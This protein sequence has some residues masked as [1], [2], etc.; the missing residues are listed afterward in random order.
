MLHSGL[1]DIL[2]HVRDVLNVQ[3]DIHMESHPNDLTPENLRII[4]SLGVRHLSIG[5]EALQDRHL[6]TLHRPYTVA[7]VKEAV[8]R[9]VGAG[10]DCVNVDAIF[11]LPDQTLSEV[12]EL[13]RSFVEL[14]VDQVA[15]YP[16]YE[17][18]YTRWE[19]IAR[20][21]GYKAFGAMAKR[22]MLAVLESI[23]YGAGFRR[24]SVWAFTRHGVPKYCSVTVPLYLGLGAAGGTYLKDVFYFNSFDVPAYVAALDRGRL[25]IALS[26]ELSEPMQMAGWLYWR[27]Y[28]TRFRK[29]DFCKRFGRSFDEVYGRY[30]RPLALLGLVRQ[31]EDE[32]VCTHGGSY[33]LHWIEDLFSIDYISSLWGICSRDPWPEGVVIEV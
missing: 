9:A 27:L 5:V 15:A 32:V 11:A 23:F 16:L 10:F 30:I 7:Q 8:A 20:H 29:S 21:N 3:C 12:D 17:F 19:E 26:L 2:A 28:E 24:T 22:R 33:W 13:G 1:G 25:P 31:N 14:G 18:P 4:S 6:K